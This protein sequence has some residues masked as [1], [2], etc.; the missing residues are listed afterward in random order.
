MSRIN[1]ASTGVVLFDTS[2]SASVDFSVDPALAN[3]YLGAFS[4][5]G[6][7]PI[8]YNGTI[9]LN[10]IGKFADVAQAGPTLND[11]GPPRSPII[12]SLS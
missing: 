8:Y 3:I 7:T 1:S 9:T 2:N 10:N 4:N 12:R 6:G 11:D 5:P